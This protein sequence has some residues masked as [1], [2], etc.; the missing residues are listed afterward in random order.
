MTPKIGI[1][2]INIGTPDEPTEDALRR[3]LAEF[4]GDPYVIDYPRWLWNPILNRIILRSRPAKSARLYAKIWQPEGSPLLLTTQAIAD[5]IARREPDFLI[6]VGMRYG[7][8]SISRALEEL[9]R[10]G[11]E[12]LVV[13]P[14]FPQYSS[15]TTGTA[16]Q[17]VS[18]ELDGGLTFQS[19]TIIEEYHQHPAYINALEASIQQAWEETGKPEKTVFS[20]H[21]VPRRYIT[22]KGEPYQ[23]QCRVTADLTAARLGLEQDE[24]LVTFQSRFGPETWLT[25]YT[26]EALAA[27]GAE[28]CL[29]LSVLCPGFAADCLET[30]E[31]IAIEGRETYEDAG[32]ENFEYIPALNE[33]EVHINALIQILRDNIPEDL[34]VR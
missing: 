17:A 23:E 21:G 28:N 6:A 33:R 3:Y 13:L 14:L 7:E 19:V 2:I 18:S 16:R 34:L 15:S 8:P 24:Y 27:L 31:E 20:F 25:P 22:R 29:S 26:D 12:H 30:L 4:L 32:G 5:G 11:A 10:R 1:L 9:L